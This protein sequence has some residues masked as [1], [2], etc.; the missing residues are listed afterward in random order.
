MAAYP[1]P[2]FSFPLAQLLHASI[3][4]PTLYFFPASTPIQKVKGGAVYSHSLGSLVP[5]TSILREG[6]VV[7]AAGSSS[8]PFV[9]LV[10]NR[11]KSCTGLAEL[12]STPIK[13][14]PILNEAKATSARLLGEQRKL[15]EASSNHQRGGIL[16]ALALLPPPIPLLYYTHGHGVADEPLPHLQLADFFLLRSSHLLSPT[17]RTFSPWMLL[18]LVNKK[19][20]E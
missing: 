14:K 8:C 10:H 18:A 17:T 1:L 4:F 15:V 16:P 20:V 5:A 11:E 12:P 9:L 6:F 7:Q 2:S 13:K 3:P 19:R